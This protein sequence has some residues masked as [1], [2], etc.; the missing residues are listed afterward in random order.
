MGKESGLGVERD[1]R[2]IIAV[3]RQGDLDRKVLKDVSR[4]FYL[5]L[6]FLPSAFRAPTS[7]GYLLA[8]ASDTIADAGVGESGERREALLRFRDW[9]NDGGD[10]EVPRLAGLSDGEAILMDRLGECWSALVGLPEWQQVAVRR[11][12]SI[13]TEGQIWDLVR[14]AGDGVV[15]L[16]NE[17]ELRG[18]AYQV[19]GCVGEFW[20]EIG[21]GVDEGFSE[22]SREEMM[23]LG[24][25]YGEGLQLINIL[26]DVGE[27]WERGRCYLPGVGSNEDLWEVRNRWLAEAREGMDAGEAYARALRGKRLRFG[28]ILPALIGRETLDLLTRVEREEW[29]RK[30]KI[31][32][33][34]VRRLMGKAARFAL[35]R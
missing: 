17:D 5:S 26:R 33:S 9:V 13:I 1:L 18:Y 10:F 8:R 21:M 14:F 22:K 23:N 19:A 20:T 4:S 31:S 32:R 35:K 29:M 25:R 16:S 27:D 6:R 30:V 7:V 3:A 28:T 24:R 15:R 12:V 11:V 34:E 2:E